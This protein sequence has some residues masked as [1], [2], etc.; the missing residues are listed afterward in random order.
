MLLFWSAAQLVLDHILYLM[1]EAFSELHLLI[2]L[3]SK[4]AG[5]YRP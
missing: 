1:L 5:R 4:R 2:G 3:E